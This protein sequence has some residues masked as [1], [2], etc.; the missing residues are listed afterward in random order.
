VHTLTSDNGREFAGHEALSG[1]PAADFFF[2]RPRHSRERGLNGHTNGPVREH[3]PKGTDFRRV[4]DADV[5]TVEKRLN[6]C[7]RRM[8]GH[9]TPDEA[10]AAARSPP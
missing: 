7:P 2:A 10:F 9:R 1:T 4:S 3:L 6:R 5:R 8:L